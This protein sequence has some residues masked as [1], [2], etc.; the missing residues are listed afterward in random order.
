MK[1]KTNNTENNKDLRDRLKHSELIQSSL[2][3][4]AKAAHNTQN[5]NDLYS[6]IHNII[7]KL[8]YADNFYIAIYNNT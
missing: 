4:I 1:D 7:K 5:L 6:S 8:M 3:K 2:Y